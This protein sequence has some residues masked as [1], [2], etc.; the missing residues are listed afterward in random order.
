MDSPL[1]QRLTFLGGGVA[2][3][4][5]TIIARAVWSSS[6][7]TVSVIDPTEQPP[8]RT[9]CVWGAPSPLLE[10]A[11][12]AQWSKLCF[13]YGTDT[14]TVD[15]DTWS[16]RQYTASS[17]RQLAERMGPI[18]RITAMAD[19]PSDES[20]LHLDSR[21]HQPVS[22]PASV[23]LLQH[24]YGR[25]IRTSKD[26]FQ[27]DTAVMMDF[28]T[29]Q[30][31]GICFLYV[32]PY[33]STE[34]LV[35]CT[36]FSPAVWDVDQYAHRLDTYIELEL[37]CSDYEV[38]ATETGVIPMNDRSVDR[39]RGR[40][41]IVIGSAGALTKPTTGYMVARCLRDATSLFVDAKRSGRMSVPSAPPSRFAWYDKLLLRIM[42]DE[43]E[44]VPL[45]LW[46]LF[47]RNPIHRIL[48]FLDEQTSL[49]QEVLLFLRLPWM[50][51][52]RAI[53]RQ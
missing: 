3:S 26:I 2:A 48:S 5:Y 1:N 14:I 17:L 35:E 51:F 19:D 32:L 6:E 16:Y 33:S 50:P 49:R 39:N 52:L 20:V 42:R 4:I 38:L 10:D 43:P 36:A 28:R 18:H 41:W 8:E 31:D 11:V 47:K 7:L 15:L 30:S 45:I 25:R 12:V 40:N 34:A 53:V 23:E 37:G 13:G 46:T 22:Q 44:V 29:D 24:F 27:P 9:L 21:P